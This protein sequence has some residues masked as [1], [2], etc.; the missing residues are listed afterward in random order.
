M[1]GEVL[2]T[3]VPVATVWTGPDAPRAGIDDPAVIDL[4]D[5]AGWA[6][7]MPA[8]VR[9][10]LAGRTLTQL[11][12]GEPVRVLEE[13]DE[14]LL[15]TALWQPS[16]TGPEGYVGWVR[17]AHLAAPVPRADGASVYVSAT[18]A[19]CRTQSGKNF[20]V[21]F[22]TLL[23]REEQDGTDG[24]VPV[25]LPGGGHGWLP[26]AAVRLSDKPEA[27]SWAAAEVLGAARR[28]LGLRYL[29]GGTSAWGL[30]CSGLVHL[31]YRSLGRVV[32]RD[33][34]DQGD[35][36]FGLEPVPL[37]HVRPGDLYFFARPGERIYH[38]GFASRPFGGD[39][40]RWMLHA[41]EGGELIEDAPIAPH[42][43][44]T[45]VSAARVPIG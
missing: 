23:W 17:R 43:V 1:I 11:L 27:P 45:L 36:A 19:E 24:D 31:M 15:V 44:D 30:D 7:S 21:S 37:N 28:F 20:P 10:G 16:S 42:R 41:P 26:A 40:V 4:P 9:K 14:W 8:E 3:C 6:A 35:P 25:L 2:E 34:F 33:A 5:V 38:V 22:G 39:G 29:W 18:T 13:R 12:L 32:P